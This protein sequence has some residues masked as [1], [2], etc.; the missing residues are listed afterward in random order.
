MPENKTS[1]ILEGKADNLVSTLNR[2]ERQIK[3]FGDHA[4]ATFRRV[5]GSI[6]AFSDRAVNSLSMLGVGLGAGELVKNMMDFDNALRKIG[7]TGGYSAAQMQSLRQDILALIDPTSKLQIPLEKGEWT[8]IATE[9]NNV[10]VSLKTIRDIMPAIGKGAVASHTGPAVY[11]EAIGN[12]LEKYKVAEKDLPILQEGLNKALKFP[13]I[14]KNPEEFLN[15]LKSLSGPMQVLGETGLKN[16]QPLVAALGQIAAVTGAAG[17]GES[18]E[19]LLNG[20]LRLSREAPKIRALH[21]IGV[22]FFDSKGKVKDMGGILEA[23]KKL[24]DWAKAHNKDIEALA[25]EVLGRPQAGRALMEISQHYDEI[26]KKQQDLS[27]SSND[28]ARD[29]VTESTSMASKIKEL[30]N[31]FDHFKAAHMEGAIKL[32]TFALDELNKHPLIAKGLIAGLLGAGGVL[33]LGKVVSAFEGIIKLFKGGGKGGVPGISGG[34]IGLPVFVTNWPGGGGAVPLGPSPV[35]GGAGG[36]AKVGAGAALAVGVPVAVVGGIV[37]GVLG[38]TT[39]AMS[40]GGPPAYWSDQGSQS[41]FYTAERE[42]IFGGGGAG[43]GA[44]TNDIHLEV[45]IRGDQLSAE[46]RDANTRI[47]GKLKRGEFF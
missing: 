27:A 5:E 46:S 6:K 40:R 41:G 37:G 14:R 19:A 9:L 1:I 8:D 17:A 42:R 38:A 26:K 32:I 34:G 11:A 3:T 29:F 16:V 21:G 2:S 31:Q 47:Y 44:V 13:D 4:V 10:G 12:L 33:L 15:V 7:R 22:D 45:N 43:S 28:L 25:M 18:M 30:I 24:G 39:L 20:L 35:G 36:A 23:A